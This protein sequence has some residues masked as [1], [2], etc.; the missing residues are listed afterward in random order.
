MNTF[1]IDLE[2]VQVLEDWLL[3]SRA[4]FSLQVEMYAVFKNN[5]IVHTVPGE[6]YDSTWWVTLVIVD[7]KKNERKANSKEKRRVEVKKGDD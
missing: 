4:N 1:F 6:P 3:S 5:F 7:K 2:Y